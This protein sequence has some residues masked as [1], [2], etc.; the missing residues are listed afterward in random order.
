[1]KKKAHTSFTSAAPL[2]VWGERRREPDYDRFIAALV[3]LAMRKVEEAGPK[4]ERE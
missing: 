2:K 1:M 4:E 3:A